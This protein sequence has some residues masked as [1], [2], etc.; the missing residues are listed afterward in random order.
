MENINQADEQY[1]DFLKGQ[2]GELKAEKNQSILATVFRALTGSSHRTKRRQV[3]GILPTAVTLESTPA[4]DTDVGTDIKQLAPSKTK[5][6]ES[7][8]EQLA[9]I[10]IVEVPT[11]PGFD[12]QLESSYIIE[13]QVQND[14]HHISVCSLNL[15]A[16]KFLKNHFKEWLNDKVYNTFNVLFG[17]INVGTMKEALPKVSIYNDTIAKFV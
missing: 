1:F 7:E 10:S 8:P 14:S 13:M 3:T 11:Q 5:Q 9:P 15:E 12:I 2:A 4:S 16:H 17:S 6:D